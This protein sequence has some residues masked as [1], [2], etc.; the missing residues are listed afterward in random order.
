VA[1]YRVG[2]GPLLGHRFLLLAHRGRRTGRRYETVLE[3]VRWRAETSEAV[4]LAGLGRRAQ[5]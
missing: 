4:V 1:L 3:V 5:W 2:A